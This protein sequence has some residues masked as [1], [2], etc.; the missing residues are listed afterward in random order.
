MTNVEIFTAGAAGALVA[1][2]VVQVLPFGLRLAGTEPTLTLTAARVFG[3][4]L[5]TTVYIT[6]GGV[7]ALIL[8]GDDET[9]M[10]NALV[11]GLGWQ[12]TVGGFLTGVQKHAE[13]Q[14]PDVGPTRGLT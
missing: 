9:T 13:S 3:W 5:V 6:A 14:P 12:S 2:L 11:Y 1:L 4:L 7:I 8:A 10:K